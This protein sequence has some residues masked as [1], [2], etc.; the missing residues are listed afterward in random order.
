[1]PTLAQRWAEE[2]KE[3]GAFANKIEICKNLIKEGL[4]LETISKVT[5][6]SLEKVLEIKKNLS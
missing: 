4:K 2:G 1:M 3:K 6:L 5:G